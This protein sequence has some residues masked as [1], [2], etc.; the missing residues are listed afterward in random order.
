[1]INDV[2]VKSF[3]SNVQ[4]MYDVCIPCDTKEAHKLDEENIN[5]NGRKVIQLEIQ[6]LMDYNAFIDIG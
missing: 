5:D 3:H 4:Y 6:Q 1:M 2:K